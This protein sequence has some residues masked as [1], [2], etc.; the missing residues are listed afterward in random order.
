MLDG[1]Q[2]DNS[3]AESEV[4]SQMGIEGGALA[5]IVLGTHASVV[6]NRRA[7]IKPAS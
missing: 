4:V 2:S 1:N 7:A 6:V 5:S 3:V